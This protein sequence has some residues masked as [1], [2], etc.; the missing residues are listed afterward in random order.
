MGVR[1]EVLTLGA[2]ALLGG[3]SACRPPFVR[4]EA[5][6]LPMPRW[7]P[8]DS[9]TLTEVIVFRQRPAP[10]LSPCQ[11][12]D[13]LIILNGDTVTVDSQG[14][15]VWRGGTLIDLPPS[16]IDSI[17]LVRGSEA[18]ARFGDA[19][20]CGALLIRARLTDPSR[21]GIR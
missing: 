10:P 16:A 8:P 12:R 13:P 21:S 2:V 9:G 14:K 17:E 20:K 4:E 18:L 3:A 11:G 19:A 1:T 5:A 7:T 15:A 6:P